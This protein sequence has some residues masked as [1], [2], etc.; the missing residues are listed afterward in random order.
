MNYDHIINITFGPNAADLHLNKVRVA[1]AFR[2]DESERAATLLLQESNVRVIGQLFDPLVQKQLV[3]L[4]IDEADWMA[5]SR[6]LARYPF[7][8][9]RMTKR[10]KETLACHICRH[11]TQGAY[12]KK[13]ETA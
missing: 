12:P 1:Y 4:P 5:L 10:Q 11:I 7:A 9:R 13:K 6:E 2:S 8:V 3:D